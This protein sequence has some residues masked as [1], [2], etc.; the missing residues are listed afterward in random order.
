MESRPLVHLDVV[1][2]EKGSFG[3]PSTKV[4]YFTYFYLKKAMEPIL[5]IMFW[6]Y[7]IMQICINSFHR[8]I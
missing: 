7:M 1:A 4:A 2:V 3:S 8:L 6:G 5:L